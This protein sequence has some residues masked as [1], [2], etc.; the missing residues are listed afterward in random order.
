MNNINAQYLSYSA[1]LT[2]PLIRLMLKANDCRKND[3]ADS[4]V[5]WRE[6]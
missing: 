1:M 4:H 2:K 5:L 6:V 3:K